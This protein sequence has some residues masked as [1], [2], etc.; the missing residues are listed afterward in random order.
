MKEKL[1]PPPDSGG[2]ENGSSATSSVKEQETVD[3]KVAEKEESKYVDI[4]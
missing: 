3:C 1:K 4:Y 2:G